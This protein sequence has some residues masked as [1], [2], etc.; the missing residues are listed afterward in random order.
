MS[1]YAPETGPDGRQRPRY[2]E[3]ATPE[4][5]RA[6][7]QQPDVTWQL[8][9]GGDAAAVAASASAAVVDAAQKPPRRFDRIATAVL[10]A[11]GLFTVI[12]SAPR[13]ADYSEFADLVLSTMGVQA[14]LSDPLGA[15][16][17]G[18]A[19]AAVLV[20]GWVAAAFWSWTRLRAN[21][22]AWWVPL[23]A[24]VVVNVVASI[25]MV[26]PL[27]SDPAILEAITATVTP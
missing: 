12:T 15:R 20:I 23:V 7:I 13:F 19:A 27:M 16:A 8:E 25:L 6:R 22:L 26:V 18:I 10:L 11:Y 17:W 1:D 2:G 3:Y 14:T 24:G 9:T 5:Q 4:D 21:R